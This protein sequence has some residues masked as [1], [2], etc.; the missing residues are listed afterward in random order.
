VNNRIRFLAAVLLAALALSASAAE[1]LQA[2]RLPP[3]TLLEMAA[4]PDVP[5]PS[6]EIR[7][8]RRPLRASARY[9]VSSPQ[10]KPLPTAGTIAAPPIVAGFASSSSTRLSPADASGA[11]SRTHVVGAFNSGIVVQNR[12]GDAIA[13]VSLGQFWT[14]QT[15][16]AYYDPRIAYDAVLD[17][18]ITLA[19]NDEQSLMLAVSAN[20]DPTG[21]W[22][23]YELGLGATGGG[24]DFS[25]LALTRDSIVIVTERVDY[26]SCLIV[27]TQKADLYAGG[28]TI[29]VH[30]DDTRGSSSS[31]VPVA[32]TDSDIDYLLNANDVGAMA[33]KRVDEARWQ[34][35]TAP[36]QWEAGWFMASQRDTS[37][38]LDFGLSEV[39]NAVMRNGVIY[40]V[41]TVGVLATVPRPVVMWWKIDAAK[42]TVIGQGILDDGKTF[43]GYPSI[44]VNRAGALIAY[45]VVSN[46]DTRRRASSSWTPRESS[47][48]R[49]S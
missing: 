18:W 5:P 10:R 16:N 35:M 29:P 13:S 25:R 7:H 41:Q 26:A 19:I 44:A 38:D 24:I 3:L 31:V 8:E 36:N 17:R 39:Q 15:S 9:E 1:I 47:A 14:D 37:N 48:T 46:A 49:R 27:S 43:Y 20:G 40:A 28:A 23:R 34:N 2:K 6:R 32:T 22:T 11:V 30:V 4:R 42:R 21:L 33:I 45:S 12:V